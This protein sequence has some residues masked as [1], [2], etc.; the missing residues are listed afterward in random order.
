MDHATPPQLSGDSSTNQPLT[1]LKLGGSLI[2]DKN[3]PSTARLDVLSRLANEIQSARQ[4]IPGMRMV[5]GHGSGSFGHVVGERYSTRLGVN[6]PEHWRGFSE[7][8]YQASRLN[9]MVVD[10]LHNVGLPVVSFSPSSCLIAQDGEVAS[11]SLDPLKSALEN[12]LLP[13]IFG[14]VVFDTLR[15]GTIFS[16]EDIFT[17]LAQHLHPQRILYAGLEAGV[18]ADYPTCTHLVTEITPENLHS[19]APTLGESAA[20]DVTGGMASKVNQML[21]LTQSQ[22]GLEVFIFSGETHG[23]VQSALSGEYIGTLIH[24]TFQS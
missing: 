13:L 18:W 11:W 12:G 15:G 3:R 20:T 14:D 17:H 10:A 21:A 23:A 2:T 22:P 8:W 7:V 4:Q 5:L 1:F 16:T 6:S 19:V 24:S 9:R